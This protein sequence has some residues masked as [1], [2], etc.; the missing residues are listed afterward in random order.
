MGFSRLQITTNTSQ[1]EAQNRR[2]LASSRLLNAEIQRTVVPNVQSR[3]KNT[4]NKPAPPHR[5]PTLWQSA[6]QMRWWFAV[7]IKFWHGRTGRVLAWI[8]KAIYRRDGGDMSLANP[9]PYSR[10]VFQP[11]FKQRMHAVWQDSTQYSQT[12]ARRVSLLIA[13][14]WHR[15]GRE[16]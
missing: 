3:L 2:I 5:R 10:F 6:K 4:L 7:G 12:E 9:V 8:V 15:I 16:G 13:D 11:P 1:I 14:A